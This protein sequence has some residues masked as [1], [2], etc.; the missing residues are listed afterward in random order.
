MAFSLAFSTSDYDQGR[1]IMVTDASTGSPFPAMVTYTLT[2][3][4]IYS[5]VTLTTKTKS[6]GALTSGFTIEVK[7][8]DLGYT[9]T[10]VIPDSVYRMVLTFNTGET[11]TSDEVVY[12]TACY[13]R[14]NFLATN[15]AYIDDVYNKD[16]DY[17]N[18]LDVLITGL[19]AN[20][21]AGNSSAVYY[22][23]DI[24]S[25]LNA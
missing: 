11:Y 4:S 22:I 7:N 25:R 16:Q 3:T 5:G 9:A 12:Y 20:A 15:A 17:A 19:E 2:V 24:F 6:G 14:D 18:W 8:T 13:T 21:V 10:E 1:S 23:L